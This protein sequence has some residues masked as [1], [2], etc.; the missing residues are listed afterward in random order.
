[1]NPNQPLRWAR[2]YSNCLPMHRTHIRPVWMRQGT[3][4]PACAPS[5]INSP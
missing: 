4:L 2:V 5:L 1:M 3:L